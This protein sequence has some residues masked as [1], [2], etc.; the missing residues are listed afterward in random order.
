MDETT[1]T[2]SPLNWDVTPDKHLITE[3]KIPIQLNF[4]HNW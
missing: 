3:M 4:M 2:S 1:C